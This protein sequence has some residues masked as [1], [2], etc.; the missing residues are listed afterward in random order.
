MSQ[1]TLVSLARIQT[2]RPGRHLAHLCEH[3]AAEAHAEWADDSG[4]ILFDFGACRLVAE[5]SALVLTAEGPDDE[6]LSRVEKITAARLAG[7]GLAVEWKR[8]A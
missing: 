7:D 6:S 4:I 3:F 1:T 5:E 8:T 2:A